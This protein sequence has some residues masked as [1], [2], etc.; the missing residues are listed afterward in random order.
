MIALA[1]SLLAP[2]APASAESFV[3]LAG[4]VM[5]PVGNDDWTNVID[6]SPKLAVRGG[7]GRHGLEGML[8]F[9]W[10][11]AQAKTDPVFGDVSYNRFRVLV[12]AQLRQA[13]APRIRL[14]ARLGVGVDIAHA[15]YTVDI[16]FV[17]TTSGSDTHTGFA[18][19]PGVGLW[20]A[21]G[22]TD[23]GIEL[24]L[25]VSTHD[26]NANTQNGE[27]GF[28]YTSIDVDL[29]ATVRFNAL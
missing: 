11:P 13:I 18:F 1:A 26:R 10:T 6:V 3:E 7:A 29:L 27:I 9:D 12:G 4:G 15:G 16:P 17:G 2:A 20:Y 5:F 19:E 23:L 8:S 25:P 21:L 24:A 22:S 14:S 28:H